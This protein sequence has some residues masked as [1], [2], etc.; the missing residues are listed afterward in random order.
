MYERCL[1]VST[2][3]FVTISLQFCCSILTQILVVWLPNPGLVTSRSRFITSKSQSCDLHM[4]VL[5]APNTSLATSKSQCCDFQTRLVS[6]KCKY[7]GFGI[8]VCWHLSP[9]LVTF[10]ILLLWLPSR[11]LVTP[12]SP[13]YERQMLDLWLPNRCLMTWKSWPCDLQML[14]LWPPNAGLV[15]SKF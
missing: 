1:A 6:A 12:T 8:L 15:T 13:S 11:S 14:V 7:C 4:A 9:S 3:S 2:D 10:Q 5:W